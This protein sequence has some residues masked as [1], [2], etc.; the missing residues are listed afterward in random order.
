MCGS[1]FDVRTNDA[2]V[3]QRRCV[4]FLDRHFEVV[5]FW[6]MNRYMWRVTIVIYKYAMREN[7]VTRQAFANVHHLPV[8]LFLV[9]SSAPLA[10]LGA[11]V[12]ND[13]NSRHG[14]SLVQCF[15]NRFESE[16]LIDS[17]SSEYFTKNLSIFLCF[18]SIT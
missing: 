15:S 6:C 9:Q 12:T 17:I 2:N 18:Y 1:I 4:Q 13:A 7:K 11:G 10:Y 8:N 3:R 16:I 5:H 14:E